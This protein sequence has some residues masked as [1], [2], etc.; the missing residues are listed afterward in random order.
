[1]VNTKNFDSL[2]GNALTLHFC[3]SSMLILFIIIFFF[4]EKID[5]GDDLS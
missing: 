3:I 5:M 4:E 1:M 2:D